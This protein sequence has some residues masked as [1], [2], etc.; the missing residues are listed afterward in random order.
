MESGSK[1]RASQQI[2]LT[3]GQK[4]RGDKTFRSETHNKKKGQTLPLKTVKKGTP[5]QKKGRGKKE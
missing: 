3:G 2:Q 4:V 5:F 1:M